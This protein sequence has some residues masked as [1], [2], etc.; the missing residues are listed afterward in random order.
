MMEYIT[1][2]GDYLV[3]TMIVTDPVWLEEPFIQTTHY[4]LDPHTQLTLYPCTVSE[5]NISTAVPHFLPG[6]NPNLGA[7]DIPNAA[8]Q[9]RRGIDLSGVPEEVEGPARPSSPRPSRFRKRLRLRPS[10]RRTA[11][12]HVLPVQGNVYML[13]GAGGNITASIGKDGI[14]L[15][16]AG[17]ADMSRESDVDDPPTRHRDHRV[18]RAQP[19]PRPAL[20][21][22]AGWMDQPVAQRHHQLPR[23]AQA[24]SLHHQYQRRCGSHRRE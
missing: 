24:G 22:D 18:A 9:R 2:H 16:D 12:I 10:R 15:V 4:E 17:P 7:D 20:R 23:A 8:A 13:V 14:L 5:E 19:L 11:Q 6:Q 1:R 3:I 21:A